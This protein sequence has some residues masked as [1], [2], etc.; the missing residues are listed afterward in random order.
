M[1]LRFQL[2]RG[3]LLKAYTLK[4]FVGGPGVTGFP[5]W[6]TPSIVHGGVNPVSYTHLRAHE[7]DSYLVC[8]LLLEKNIDFPVDEVTVSVDEETGKSAFIDREN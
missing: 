7:T 5:R 1:G 4:V 2:S 3:A 6:R 8:R